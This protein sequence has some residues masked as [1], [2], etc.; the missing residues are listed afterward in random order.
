MTM[1]MKMNMAKSTN[2]RVRC[3]EDEL[4]ERSRRAY[5]R[6]CTRDGTIYQQPNSALSDV[7]GDHVVLQNVRGV[8]ATYDLTPAGGC[9]SSGTEGTALRDQRRAQ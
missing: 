7:T 8:L 5:Q 9:D 2:A 6:R 3:D 1:E 4:L